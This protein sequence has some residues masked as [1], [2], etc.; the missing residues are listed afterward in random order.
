MIEY[1]IW[2]IGKYSI[3]MAPRTKM[4]IEMSGIWG[5]ANF[6]YS[7]VILTPVFCVVIFW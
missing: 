2:K 5:W 1:K 4:G 6:A 7:E 3:H